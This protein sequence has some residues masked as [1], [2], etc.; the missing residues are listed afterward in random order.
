MAFS[1]LKKGVNNNQ[2]GTGGMTGGASPGQTGGA[3]GAKS[4]AGT[5]GGFT[6]IQDY[7]RANAG[8]TTNQNYL[9]TTA[10]KQIGN[11]KGQMDTTV[12]GLS[13]I[14]QNPTANLENMNDILANNKYTDAANYAKTP[15]FTPTNQEL[16]SIA[17]P[18]AGLQ[19][20][21]PSVMD[22]I[23]AIKPISQSYTPGMAGF[24]EMLLAGDKAFPGQ[25][26]ESK[27]GAFKSQVADP[28]AAK[29]AEREDEK[30]Q[31]IDT[32]NAWRDQM[33]HFLGGQKKAIADEQARQQ[34]A[35]TKGPLGRTPF[36]NAIRANSP[37]YF[38]TLQDINNAYG[39]FGRARQ[40]QVQN[41]DYGLNSADILNA[42]DLL[43]NA[44]LVQ[45]ELPSTIGGSL[46]QQ[47]RHG[48]DVLKSN[49]YSDIQNNYSNLYS[50]VA[51][52][53]NENTAYTAL[54]TPNG[55]DFSND[56][57]AIAGIIGQPNLAYQNQQYQPGYYNIN[58]NM[59]PAFS[60][61]NSY[62]SGNTQF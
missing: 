45:N 34:I 1:K 60:G 48:G 9:N 42:S 30:K 21:L 31:A 8:D 13:A 57:N 55:G 7:M 33:S 18:T 15:T 44:G 39:L 51:P 43:R 35:G 36:M 38:R 56:Y 23:G 20:T 62:F 2:L 59:L 52:Q 50:T 54:N 53:A 37:D 11:A 58:A 29:I 14:N 32:T 16:P 10:D 12:G 26:A 3:T 17:D 25:F 5:P 19:G 49:P 4:D 47:Y 27:K 28:Y 61:L 6:N 24:D 46:E 41:T 40:E 22:Y